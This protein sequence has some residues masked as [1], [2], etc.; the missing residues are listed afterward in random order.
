MP[1]ATNQNPCSL[2]SA[3][4]CAEAD[5]GLSLIPSETRPK[6]KRKLSTLPC[7]IL[8]TGNDSWRMKHRFA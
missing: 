4:T 7:E 2:Q 8:E 3:S 5:G 1:Q 6:K